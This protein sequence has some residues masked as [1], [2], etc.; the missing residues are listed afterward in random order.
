MINMIFPLVLDL[1][2]VSFVQ[3]F[4]N[5]KCHQIVLGATWCNSTIHIVALRVGGGGGG[6]GRGITRTTCPS[7]YSYITAPLLGYKSRQIVRL[8]PI[9]PPQVRD[10]SFIVSV[11]NS[12]KDCGCL[13]Q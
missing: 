1:Q 2:K 8:A 5:A 11:P 7:Q 13:S 3:I 10:H 9:L 6:G 12:Y 4:Y